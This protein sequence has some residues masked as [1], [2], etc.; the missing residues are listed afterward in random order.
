MCLASTIF[1][2]ML[3]NVIACVLAKLQQ[4]YYNRNMQTTFTTNSCEE[5]EKIAE[6]FAH[7]LSGGDVVLLNGELG[8]GKTHFAKG[9]ARGLG[10]LDV[11][12]SPTFALHNSYSGEVYIFNHFD[13]YRVES[14][15]EVEILGLHEYFFDKNGV[16]AIEWCENVR[17]LLPEKT[18]SVS[19]ETVSENTRKIVIDSH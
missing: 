9:L 15:S 18:I 3:T 11:V 14:S 19:I 4:L 16:C 5:T 7:T 12:T 10:V 8:A 1:L 13:F 2:Q 17:E 6:E